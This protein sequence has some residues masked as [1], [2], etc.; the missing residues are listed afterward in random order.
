MPGEELATIEEF[1]VGYG[2]YS[3]GDKVRASIVGKAIYD[4]KAR[5]VKLEPL[6]KRLLMPSEGD[7]VLGSVEM[8][9]GPIIHVRIKYINGQ[10]SNKG[11]IGL[12]L[13]QNKNEDKELIKVSDII[14][15][16]VISLE[17]GIIHLSIEKD[18]GVIHTLCS[19]CGGK[20]KRIGDRAIKC[21]KCGNVEVRKLSKYFG[22]LTEILSS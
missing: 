8:V 21:V 15:A 22:N 19:L 3:D 6:S 10:R 5:V 1:D 16:K 18:D 14:K 20:V 9:Q 11:F 12:A 7:V 17:N 2:T 4:L 13:F